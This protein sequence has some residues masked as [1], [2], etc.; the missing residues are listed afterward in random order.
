[1]KLSLPNNRTSAFNLVELLLVVIVVLALIGA[2]VLLPRARVSN[3][4][5]RINCVNNLKQVG[6]SFRLWSADHNDNYPMQVSATNGGA[7]ELANSGI[8]F[9][10]FQVMSNELNTPIILKCPADTNRIRAT[11]FATDFNSSKVSYFVGLDAVETNVTMLLSGDRNLTT[12]GNPVRS[13]L[14]T[15]T[16]KSR[17]GWSSQLHSK[18]GNVCLAD[19]T[20]LQVTTAGLQ[21]LVEKTGVATNRLVLP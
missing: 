12:N 20:V 21:E 17:A 11:N 4:A 9:P 2:F 1:M 16:T 7:M 15:L 3:S 10:I 8:V 14:V 18:N 5:R 13:H 6:L 19:G